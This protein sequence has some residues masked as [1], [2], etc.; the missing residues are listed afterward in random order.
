[1]GDDV[2]ERQLHEQLRAMNF[3]GVVDS[4]LGEAVELFL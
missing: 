4:R 2:F 1:L 3:Y